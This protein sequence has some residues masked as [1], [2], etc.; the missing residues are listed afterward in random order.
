MVRV[1]RPENAI[2]LP[3]A[4]HRSLLP[5][6]THGE[7]SVS[8]TPFGMR[9]PSLPVAKSMTL[10]RIATAEGVDKRYERSWLKGIH[11]AFSKGNK[12][13][14]KGKAVEEDS[15]GMLLRRGDILW[16]PLWIDKPISMEDHG[17]NDLDTS[18]DEDNDGPWLSLRQRRKVTSV[19]YFTVTSLNFEPLIPLEEDFRSSISSKARAGEYGC[20]VDVGEQGRTRLVLEGMER[21]IIP[22]RSSERR[23][24]GLRDVASPFSMAAET[25]LTDLLRSCLRKS[26]VAYMIQLSVLIKG[27]RGGGKTSVVRYIA[28][29][30]G[31]NVVTVSAGRAY[32][33]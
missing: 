20:W 12:G 13:K 27:A 5:N 9:P 17:E 21:V 2:I 6:T 11:G 33:L 25:R 8:P 4:L 14:G 22:S 1:P 7:V 32:Y 29:E 28:D 30:L 16:V 3:P 19:G 18:S 15:N 24:H 10:A 31:Y 26:A 23:S